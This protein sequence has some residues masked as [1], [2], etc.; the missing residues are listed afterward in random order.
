[1]EFFSLFYPCSVPSSQKSKHL[2]DKVFSNPTESMSIATHVEFEYLDI[3]QSK[4]GPS[5]IVHALYSVHCVQCA[6]ISTCFLFAALPRW[7][8]KPLVCC[9]LV[10]WAHLLC[11]KQFTFK[12]PYVVTC[13]KP[14]GFLVLATCIYISTISNVSWRWFVFVLHYL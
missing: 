2:T 13:Q 6:F 14:L 5:Y 10:K 4:I 3:I 8:T 1:M 12:E 7:C 11:Q 9:S